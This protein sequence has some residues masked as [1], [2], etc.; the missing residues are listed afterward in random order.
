MARFTLNLVTLPYYF[1]QTRGTRSARFVG[2]G[3]FLLVV[4]VSFGA[5]LA[6]I[7]VRV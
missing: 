6:L 3:L 4:L 5:M 7:V 1:H 2:I